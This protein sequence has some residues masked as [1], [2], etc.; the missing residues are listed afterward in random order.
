MSW[1]R[2][3]KV[4]RRKVEEANANGRLKIK[5]VAW[6]RRIFLDDTSDGSSDRCVSS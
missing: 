4:G 1:S 3:R 5:A 2:G 6:R